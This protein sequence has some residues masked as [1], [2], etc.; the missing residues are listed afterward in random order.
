MIE[1]R[2]LE[3]FVWVAQLGSFRRAAAR[4]N[5]TQPSVSQRIAQLEQQLGV[6]LLERG[7]HC[8]ALTET[9]RSV[10]TQAEGLL[11]LRGELIGSVTDRSTLRGVLRLGVAETIVHTWLPRFLEA[12]SVSYPRITLEIEV[13]TSPHLREQLLAR[14]IDIAF[15]LGP[16]SA[17]SIRSTPLCRERI[18]FFGSPKLGLPPD[19]RQLAEIVAFPIITFSRNTQPYARLRELLS[20]R[21]LTH[22]RVHSSSSLA[23]AVRM[24]LDGLGVALI[25]AS[26]VASDVKAGRLLE[27]PCAATVPDLQFVAG[28]LSQSDKSIIAPAVELAEAVATSEWGPRPLRASIGTETV[29]RRLQH[30]RPL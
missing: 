1:F 24:A 6:R 21:D 9:G 18:A 20:E 29:R 22:A 12:M 10:L 11:R 13:D 15:F 26:I 16:L 3:T 27:I 19:E 4:L 28:W 8:F 5:T 25:P 14:T 17:P 30:N 23:T 2:T 7:R